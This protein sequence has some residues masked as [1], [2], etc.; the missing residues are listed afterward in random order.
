MFGVIYN[1]F[2]SSRYSFIENDTTEKGFLLNATNSSLDPFDYHLG[3]C[4]HSSKPLEHTEKHICW[5]SFE[6]DEKMKRMKMMFWMV[7][8]KIS[9]KQI[10]VMGKMKWLKFLIKNVFYVTKEIVFMLLDKVVISLFAI[11]VIK[12]KVILIH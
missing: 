7:R 8:M 6:E 1:H 4:V 2:K 10:I 3:K 12:I 5:H 9:L 11:N